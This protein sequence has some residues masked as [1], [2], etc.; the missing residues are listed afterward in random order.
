M[1]YNFE[2]ISE[3]I[4]NIDNEIN[5]LED[6]VNYKKVKA[7]KKKKFSNKKVLVGFGIATLIISIGIGLG[8]AYNANIANSM[9][10]NA[11]MWHHVNAAEQFKLHS[12]NVR[13][14]LKISKLTNRMPAFS[15]DGIWKF[16][17]KEL[18]DYAKSSTLVSFIGIP[19]SFIGGVGSIS[20]ILKNGFNIKNFRY[21]KF[22]NKIDDISNDMHTMGINYDVYRR[23]IHVYEDISKNKDLS[24]NDKIE[25]LNKVKREL[26][27]IEVQTNYQSI[28]TDSKKKV[29]K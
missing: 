11:D 25:L 6:K 7:I 8:L 13:N 16:G 2:K 1:D 23:F 18:Y 4:E 29:R 26:R 21:T 9:V 14:A 10:L 3:N 22:D 24:Y 20:S 27:Y 12:E 19:L 5:K 15:N 28:N 17:A